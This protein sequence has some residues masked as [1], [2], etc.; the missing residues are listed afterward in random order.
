LDNQSGTAENSIPL[1]VKPIVR[2][3]GPNTHAFGIFMRVATN[4]PIAVN[5]NS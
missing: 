5:P 3:M 4:T 1:A 2:N